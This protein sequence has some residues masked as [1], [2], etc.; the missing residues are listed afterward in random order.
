MVPGYIFY[1]YQ[2][3]N[4]TPRTLV[5][6]MEA[7]GWI[8]DSYSP[9]VNCHALA[10]GVN[11]ILCGCTDGTIRAFDSAGTETGTAVIM[12]RA[13]N[14]G[15][16]RVVK[17]IGGVFLRAVAA[18]A[19]TLA[20]WANR[21]QTAITGFSPSTAGTGSSE[22]D[23]LID[24]TSAAHA[25]VRDLAC[26]FSWALGS[27]N[28]L[29]E[30]Q[31]DWTFLPAQ[32]IGWKTGLLSYGLEGWGYLEWINLAYQSTATVTLVMTPAGDQ[33]DSLPIVTLTFPSTGGI[34]TKQ[35]MTFP[36]NKFKVAGWT[37]SSSE[38]FT[39]FAADSVAML[40]GWGTKSGVIKVLEGWGVPTSTT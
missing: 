14:R 18:S 15:S 36:A 3:T 11:Q 34:Q 29:S 31:P 2:D 25:D 10:V 16:T 7:K 21:I 23:Y 28:I 33:S 1:D 24:F 39:I 32:I 35:F 30:W 26:Q 37:A 13:D 6:D 40:G 19:V 17:R 38:P 12:T 8:V 27:G 4:G 5:Y 9:T 22:A 20:F